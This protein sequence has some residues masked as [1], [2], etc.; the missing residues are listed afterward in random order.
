MNCKY[1]GAALPTKGGVCPN[2]GK[3]VPVS[4]QKE[5][6]RI[7]DPKWNEYRNQNTDLYK[8]ESNNDSMKHLNDKAIGNIVI[9]CIVIFIVIILIILANHK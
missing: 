5:M 1:C 2:C 9:A 8:R 6:K 3:M 4:Q 7:L